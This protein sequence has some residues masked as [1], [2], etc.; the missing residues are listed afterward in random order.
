MK[1][2]A[3]DDASYEEMKFP[4]PTKATKTSELN[5]NIMFQMT[6]N[7]VTLSKICDADLDVLHLIVL[8]DRSSNREINIIKSF[9]WL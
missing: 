6:D 5:E 8:G 1:R 7:L 9:N 2:A 4:K 3:D